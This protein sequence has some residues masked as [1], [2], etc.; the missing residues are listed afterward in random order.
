M[1]LY[2]DPQ[3]LLLMQ[4]NSTHT[5]LRYNILNYCFRNKSY[6]FE[7]LLGTLNEGISELYLGEEV[8]ERTLREDI[9][10]FRDKVTSF[11]APLPEGQ[12]TY[13]YIH[14]LMLNNKNIS[15]QIAY[16]KLAHWFREVEASGFKAFNT[17]ANSISL[18]YQS[19]LNYFD[20]R[21]TNAAAESFNAKIKAFR[22]QFRGV[23]NVEFFLFRLT[24]IFA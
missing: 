3:V 24:Q 16:T 5:H 23:R 13:T 10:V 9:K 19:I 6:G 1:N 22:R 15:K 21:S 18:N 4:N 12:R 2:I 11:D 17:V 14:I 20:N 8:S 7:E